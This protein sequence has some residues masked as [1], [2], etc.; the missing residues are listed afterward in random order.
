MRSGALTVLAEAT[1]VA[2]AQ[3]AEGQSFGFICASD[4]H[5]SPAEDPTGGIVASVSRTTLVLEPGTEAPPTL[6]L[7]SAVGAVR[8]HEAPSSRTTVRAPTEDLLGSSEHSNRPAQYRP[9][10][11]AT[12]EP[13]R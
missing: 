2:S 4:P 10:R 5:L 6:S 12:N 1:G 13:R 3:G 9:M 8:D 11:R 7:T